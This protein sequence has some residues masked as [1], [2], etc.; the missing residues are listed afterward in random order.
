M[1]VG[2][3]VA[4][5]KEYAPLIEQMAAVKQET[6]GGM[7]YVSGVL[8]GHTA[9]VAVSGVGKVFAAMCAQTMILRYAPDCII[10]T[11]V[12]GSL[13][14]CLHI[15]D[16]AIADRVVQHDMDT[17][18]VGDPIGMI[19]GIGEI[20]L[21]ADAGLVATARQAAQQLGLTAQIGTIASG[22]Q[23]VADA[24]RK[25]E[26]IRRFDAIACE[27]EGAAIGQVC[28]VNRVPFAIIRAISDDAAGLAQMEYPVFA[29]KAAQQ[30][31][32]LVCKMLQNT[33]RETAR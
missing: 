2:I 26:I 8:H 3:I 13:S 16:L 1:R 25:Q 32:A 24:A 18:A 33:T 6:F 10:C 11:G 28:Y 29:A 15:C 23:F 4:M 12:A 31:V 21:P 7:T 20:Y 9:V 17:S 30:S 22:D 14:A 19:S 27:M 5:E